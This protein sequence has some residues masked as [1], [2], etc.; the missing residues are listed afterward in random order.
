[1]RASRRPRDIVFDAPKVVAE[2]RRYLAQYGLVDRWPTFAGGF[3]HGPI[4]SGGDLHLLSNFIHDSD[5]DRA[6]QALWNCHA[7]MR[8]DS[9][10][11][12]IERIMAER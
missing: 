9:R 12:L 8:D 6:V 11:L 7:A 4:P 10:L 2:A 3:F 1:M 5:D